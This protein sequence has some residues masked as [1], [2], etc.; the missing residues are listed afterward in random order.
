[1]ERDGKKDEKLEEEIKLSLRCL[2][3]IKLFQKYFM[4][5]I[6]NNRKTDNDDNRRL[7]MTKKVRRRLDNNFEKKIVK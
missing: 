6:K 2:E 3:C 5:S 7:N 1:M 4:H